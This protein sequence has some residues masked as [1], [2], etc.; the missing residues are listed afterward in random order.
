MGLYRRVRDGTESGL[1]EAEETEDAEWAE[2]CA[3]SWAAPDAAGLRLP[4]PLGQQASCLQGLNLLSYHHLCSVNILGSYT[5]EPLP[6]LA[7]LQAMLDTRNNRQFSYPRCTDDGVSALLQ[8]HPY[9]WQLLDQC[10][11]LQIKIQHLQT[12]GIETVM[13]WASDPCTRLQ[14]NALHFQLVYAKNN[15]MFAFVIAPTPGLLTDASFRV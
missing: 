10:C 7:C 15:G 13:F 12:W 5:M 2:V 8:C 6:S 4:H 14:W 1:R 9:V 11:H 3:V